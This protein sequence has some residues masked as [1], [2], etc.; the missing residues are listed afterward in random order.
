[1]W[2]DSAV[3][4]MGADEGTLHR[5]SQPSIIMHPDSAMPTGPIRTHRTR[6]TIVARPEPLMAHE[7]PAMTLWS[8]A[9]ARGTIAGRSYP[10][11]ATCL[12]YRWPPGP[13]QSDLRELA[14]LNQVNQYV[15]LVLGENRQVTSLT[16]P[17]LVASE[18]HFRALSTACWAQQHFPVV[19]CVHLLPLT[20]FS[21][22]M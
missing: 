13:R 1:M 12:V 5:A 21:R 11:E 8:Q 19:Q 20:I 3:A 15:P 18:L 4:T 2:V 10:T 16:D 17:D 22:S 9:L 7:Y 14:G 6:I